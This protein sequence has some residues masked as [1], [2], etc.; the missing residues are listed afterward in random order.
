MKAASAT[1]KT[2]KG[3]ASAIGTKAK[4]ARSSWPYTWGVGD[5]A[6]FLEA[7]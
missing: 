7:R 3:N 5:A 6:E 2:L 1:Q 4:T